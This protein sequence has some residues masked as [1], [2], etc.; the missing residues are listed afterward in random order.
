M[1]RL[2]A[3][4][5]LSVRVLSRLYRRLFLE[6]LASAFNA[7]APNFFADLAALAD[8]TAFAA[9]L[10]SLRQTEWVVFVKRPFGSPQQVTG[11]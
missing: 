9:Y 3:W 5:F 4:I 7:G 10:R 1:D 2:P 11:V 8:P 6:R